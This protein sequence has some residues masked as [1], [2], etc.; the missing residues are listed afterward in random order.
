MP[1]PGQHVF[2][3]KVALV[4]GAKG[5]LGR[6]VSMQ[7]GLYGCYVIA[8]HSSTDPGDV[9]SVD[10]LRALGTLAHSFEADLASAHGASRLMD[11]IDEVYGRLDI[12]VNC[13]SSPVSDE[14]GSVS[15]A[16]LTEA[17]DAVIRPAIFGTSE[18]LRLFRDRPK[19]R[20]VNVISY[21]NPVEPGTGIVEA[22]VNAAVES[23]T[24]SMASFLPGNYRINAVAVKDTGK[25]SAVGDE[26]DPE[27][28]SPRSGPDPDDV[29]R[30][31]LFL[32][33][34]EA[35]GVNGQVLEIV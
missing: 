16:E 30:A 7:L 12:L 9:D 10:E 28:F 11:R 27:L 22:A 5:P 32:L 25:I 6:A 31:V 15:D 4:T 1:A 20:I 18:A 34:S 26:L 17:V 35:K 21:R 14:F 19:P 24:R 33:S 23:L 29:A 8:A 2:S 3:E 13:L